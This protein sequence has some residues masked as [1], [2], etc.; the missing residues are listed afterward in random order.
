MAFVLSRREVVGKFGEY[1]VS[2]LLNLRDFYINGKVLFV[3]VEH[4]Y[5]VDIDNFISLLL[6]ICI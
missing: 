2:L 4:V 6:S 1:S 5:F 3:I